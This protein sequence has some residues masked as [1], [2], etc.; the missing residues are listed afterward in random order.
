[1]LCWYQHFGHYLCVLK[2]HKTASLSPHLSYNTFSLSRTGSGH[3]LLWTNQPEMVSEFDA[4]SREVLE[5]LCKA[6]HP[7]EHKRINVKQEKTISKSPRLDITTLFAPRFEHSRSGTSRCE[8]VVV[9]IRARITEMIRGS[10]GGLPVRFG[11]QS[12]TH[13]LEQRVNPFA[14]RSELRAVQTQCSAVSDREITDTTKETLDQF[15]AWACANG[16]FLHSV[17]LGSGSPP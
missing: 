3:V 15:I 14:R 11:V 10:T 16:V 5:F 12:R 1:M 8:D 4:C 6:L 17:R 7:N 13:C 9:R 2:L